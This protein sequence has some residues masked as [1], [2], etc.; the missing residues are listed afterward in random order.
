VTRHIVWQAALAMAGIVLVFFV[1]FQLVSG[2]TTVEV[3][4]QG[5]GFVEGVVGAASAINPLL[6]PRLAQA[7][8]VDQ[9]LSALVFEGLTTLDETGQVTPTLATGWDVSEDGTTYEFRLR[10]GVAWQDGAPF[11]A[12]DV[13]FTVQAIQDPDFQGDPALSELWRAVTVEQVDDLTVRFHLAE[14]F[15]SFLYYTTIGL[16]PA[17]LL[18]TVPAADLPSHEFTRRRPVGTGPFMVE[19]VSPDKVVLAS[20]PSYWGRRPFLDRLEFWFYGDEDGVLAAYERGEVN[21]FHPSRSRTLSDLARLPDLQLYSA[22]DAGYGAVFLNLRRETLPF[23]QVKEVRQALSYGLDR[24]ALIN[25]ALEG[26]GLVADSPILPMLWAYDPGVKR[27]PFDP[28]RARGLLDAA[29]WQD[30]DADRIRDKDGVPLAFELL[31]GDDLTMVRIAE[32]IA[33]DWRGIGADVTVRQVAADLLPAY[34]RSREFDAAL[35]DVALAADPDPYPLWHSTQAGD[36]GQNFTG[37]ADEQADL[38]MEE[39]R[40]TTDPERRGALYRTFQ[41]IFAEQV[42]AL[43]LYYPVYSYAVDADV[44]E[45]QLSPLWHPSD[46]FRNVADW[47]MATRV[48]VSDQGQLD[49]S[50]E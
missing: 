34:I 5:G 37:F 21:G 15:Q 32:Q 47:Y 33:R 16:L 49:N 25:G 20:N 29:G 1:L 13:V 17:H 35:T 9:D 44:R 45:V 10:K 3:P 50:G 30:T 38:A 46:R 36:G 7:N 26:Q 39:A 4:V 28:E 11:T 42:P 41:Q 12:A 43:L 22:E 2:R 31:S 40:S 27:Y 18:S 8:P 6:A 24:Q 23:L 19:S 14:P 48:V